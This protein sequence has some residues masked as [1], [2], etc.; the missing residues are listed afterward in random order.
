MRT[1]AD[2]AA[3]DEFDDLGRLRMQP[4]HE[5][6][7]GKDAGLLRFVI[8]GIGVKGRKRDRLFD[9]HVFAGADCLD[10]PFGMAGVRRGD[11]DRVDL[12]VRQ[13]RLIAIDD[14]GA[15]EVLGK[16][17]LV[18]IAGGDGHELAGARMG[19]AVREGAGDGARAD[20]A[21]ADRLI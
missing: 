11:I 1:V 19:D 17:R 15:R 3:L 21:P 12:A 2:D 10:R 18:G 7:A 9:E 16:A 6:F 5:G 14:A 13:Q 4:V 8:D 20:D